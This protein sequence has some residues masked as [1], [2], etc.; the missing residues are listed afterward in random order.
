[1]PPTSRSQSPEINGSPTDPKP[2]EPNPTNER[3]SGFAGVLPINPITRHQNEMQF[4]F[5]DLF[6]NQTIDTQL[7]QDLVYIHIHNIIE[8]DLYELEL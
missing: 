2:P 5:P 4:R 6:K 3:N 8:E 1:M 7:L